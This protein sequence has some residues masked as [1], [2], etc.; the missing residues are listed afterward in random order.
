[1]VIHGKGKYTFM[2]GSFP[3][4]SQDD[5][6][7]AIWESNN[8]MVMAW[9]IHFIEDAIGE[10]Y[11]FY[12][13]TKEIWDA[14]HFAYS[15]LDNSSKLFELWNKAKDLLQGGLDAIQYFRML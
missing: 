11:F 2:D 4:P 1:M 14:V 12:S 7:Y 3:H 10:T 5:P 15:D 6:S 8:S 9:F 13:T